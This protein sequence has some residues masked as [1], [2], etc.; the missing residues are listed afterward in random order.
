[1]VHYASRRLSPD[2]Q[3][4]EIPQDKDEGRH[5]TGNFGGSVLTD[6]R[7]I[8][9]R[10]FLQGVGFRDDLTYEWR[11]GKRQLQWTASDAKDA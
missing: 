6:K 10:R 11:M 9:L 1:M 8:H 7:R 3:W 5:A 2:W 4:Q